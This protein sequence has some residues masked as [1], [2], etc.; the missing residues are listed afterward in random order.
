MGRYVSSGGLVIQLFIPK[1]WYK[2]RLSTV[3]LNDQFFFGVWL[4]RENGDRVNMK[5]WVASSSQEVQP[6]TVSQYCMTVLYYSRISLC[7]VTWWCDVPLTSFSF[8]NQRRS[9]AGLLPWVMHVRVM[10]S[11]SKAGFVMPSISGFSGTPGK[12]EERE[13]RGVELRYD[14]W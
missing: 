14:M 6:D 2:L 10:W 13:I 8:R 7:H 5:Y 12:T 4:H 1:H 11:P 3:K 9:A